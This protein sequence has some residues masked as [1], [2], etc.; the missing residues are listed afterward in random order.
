MT[1]VD[2]DRLAEFA[3]HLCAHFAV[4]RRGPRSIVP[5]GRGSVGVVWRLETGAARYAV[6]EFLWGLQESEVD[7]E[8]TFRDL[9]AD[10]G[11]L[12]PANV[13]S[14][15]G[16]YLVRL[17]PELDG[18]LV[19]VYEWLDG[20]PVRAGEVPDLVGDAL[21]RMHALGAP[22]VN[23]PD[24][25][26]S[27]SP[28]EAAWSTVVAAAARAGA[29]WTADLVAALPRILDLAAIT[30]E[31]PTDAQQLLHLD[32]QPSN[33]LVVGGRLAVL[34][35]DGT[36]TGSPERELGFVLAHWHAVD[37]TVDASGAARLVERYRAAGGTARLRGLS[38]FG[39]RIATHLNYV[40]CQAELALDTDADAATRRTAEQR[41]R[42]H[43]ARL[44][45]RDDLRALLD[46]VG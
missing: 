20:T 37:G 32:V 44:P 15:S 12:S 8:V 7:R 11:I 21:G 4:E 36:D 42:D 35:W 39:M 28:D 40:H 6:K 25:W 16:G 23:D 2:D 24:P 46:R 29:E 38:S 33:L 3:D 1:A 19:R 18:K 43:L 22:P 13:P 14:T 45:R 34:D 9:T 17:P 5:A 30:A 41:T 31:P 10:V 27:T 26:Y